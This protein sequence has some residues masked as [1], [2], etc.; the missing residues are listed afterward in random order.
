MS[1][2]FSRSDHLKEKV[3]DIKLQINEWKVLFAI[4][5]KKS[6]QDIAE[7]LD[8]DT[9][10]VENALQKFSGLS[11]LSG[12]GNYEAAEV[13]DEAEM[14][15]IDTEPED[16]EAPDFDLDDASKDTVEAVIDDELSDL[17]IDDE[18][19]AAEF[20][21]SID[22]FFD[23]VEE[24]DEDVLGASEAELTEDVAE[25]DELDTGAAEADFSETDDDE[26]PF[27]TKESEDLDFDSLL[28]EAGELSADLEDE[29]DADTEES[30]TE[31]DDDFDSLIGNL[32][33]DQEMDDLSTDLDDSD[34]DIGDMDGEFDLSSIFDEDLVDVDDS[35]SETAIEET[36]TPVAPPEFTTPGTGTSPT[37]LVV[38][39][40]VVIR[41]M[42]EIALENED[43]QIVSVSSGKE[44]LNYLDDNTPDLIILDIMLSD[45]NGLDVLKAIKASKDIPVVMLSAKD[46]PRETSRAKQL[47]AD[48]FIPKPFKDEELV[49]KIKELIRK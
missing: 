37:I 36:K 26:D 32:L 21:E 2:V 11:F 5:G 3:F 18:E 30:A 47:G 29:P 25:L 16:F 19:M 9:V 23:E 41:K 35:D 49:G 40:S 44:A 42:V 13:A 1:Q 15:V 45:V 27:S 24:T 20:S 31:D 43:Y 14:G 8:L 46:T 12:N 48:D 38:D 22:N 7:F 39:D 17:D 33:D 28:S 6:A 34:T 10:V 4:D